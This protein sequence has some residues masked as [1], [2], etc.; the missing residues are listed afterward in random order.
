[1]PLMK[2]QVTARILL[3]I[4]ILIFATLA[5]IGGGGDPVDSTSPGQVQVTLAAEA[6][7][8]YGAEQFHLQLTAQAEP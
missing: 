3:I 8:T 4:L 1:M 5:C 6:T 7:A 2:K